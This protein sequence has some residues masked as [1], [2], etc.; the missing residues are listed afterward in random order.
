MK[1]PAAKTVGKPARHAKPA[2]AGSGVHKKTKATASRKHKPAAK[3]KHQPTAHAKHVQHVEHL[4]HIGKAPLAVGDVASCSA[5]ALAA[6]LR[7][8]G[9][10]VSDEDVLALYW[11]TAADPDAGATLLATLKAAPIGIL[12]G[13]GVL[14]GF[15]IGTVNAYQVLYAVIAI[16][17][18]NF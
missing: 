11:R 17:F 12:F 1:K 10:P 5:E 7:F 14:A 9:A 13:V 2:A 3:K 4:E 18:V 6:S 8:T 15:V 16:L